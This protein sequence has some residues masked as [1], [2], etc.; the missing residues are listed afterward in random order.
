MGRPEYRRRVE[1][2]PKEDRPAPFQS[3]IAQRVP[4]HGGL[5]RKTSG[6]ADLHNGDVQD[7]ISG[8]GPSQQLP[9]P[10]PGMHNTIRLHVEAHIAAIMRMDDISEAT[11]YI[12][13]V[14]CPS[15]KRLRGCD[16]SLP[17]MLPFG[18]KL[19]VY[20]PEGFCRVYTGVED[21]QR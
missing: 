11:L 20:G 2:I 17:L 4:E 1:L 10:R 18:A 5:G 3:E 9:L 21:K 7:V 13:K 14:P 16:D 8:A 15:Q 12:N 19:T 6:S